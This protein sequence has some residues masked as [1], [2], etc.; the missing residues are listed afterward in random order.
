MQDRP[1][2]AEL[3][4]AVCEFLQ[5]EVAPTLADRRA[6]FRALVAINALGILGR[7]LEQELRLVRAEGAALARLLGSAAGLP[8]DAD[9]LRARVHELNAELARRIR[10]GDVPDGTLEHLLR[11]GADKL[12]VASPGYLERY[13]PRAG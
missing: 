5:D 11:V 6:R 10:R 8:G 4:D 12:R 2:F 13:P 3:L 1:T 7:E 9:A